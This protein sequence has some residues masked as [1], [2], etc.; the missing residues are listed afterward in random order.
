MLCG[1]VSANLEKQLAAGHLGPITPSADSL[2]SK[3]QHSQMFN[4]ATPSRPKKDYKGDQYEFLS[5]D[6]NKEQ[7]SR[8]AFC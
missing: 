7:G 3:E 8:L 5:H 1:L 4:H 6:S 2:D